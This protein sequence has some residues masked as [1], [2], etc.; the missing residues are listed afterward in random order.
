MLGVLSGFLKLQITNLLE[1]EYD[2][3]RPWEAILLKHM[4]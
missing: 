3:L 2:K 1:V 4:T